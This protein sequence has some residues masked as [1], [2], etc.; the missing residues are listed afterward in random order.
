VYSLLFPYT[1]IYD[2]R[3]GGYLNYV[4]HRMLIENKNQWDE[5]RQVTRFLTDQTGRND[6]GRSRSFP[7]LRDKFRTDRG[8]NRAKSNKIASWIL[9]Y[10]VEKEAEGQVRPVTL[11]QPFRKL[12]IAFFMLGFDLS[13]IKKS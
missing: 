11:Q 1:T 2:S 13:Q 5:I 10:I 6:N 7:D 12:E 3:V 9:L 4:F 8:L